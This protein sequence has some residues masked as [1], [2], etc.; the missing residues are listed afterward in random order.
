MNDQIP[1]PEDRIGQVLKETY[2][3]IRLLGE[4]GFGSILPMA[5]GP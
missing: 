1:K 2:R 4:E 5:V 3:I